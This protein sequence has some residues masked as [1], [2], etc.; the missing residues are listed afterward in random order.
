MVWDG[1]ISSELLTCDA[2]F[3][4]FH[5]GTIAILLQPNPREL[6]DKIFTIASEV[7]ETDDLEIQVLGG[8]RVVSGSAILVNSTNTLIG[9][10]I[11]DT[12][13]DDYYRG[14]YLGMT[15][16]GETKDIREIADY[17]KSGGTVEDQC[18]LVRALSG[19]PATAEQCSIY[20]MR[21]ISQFIIT[22]ETTL[23]EDLPQNSGLTVMGFPFIIVRARSTGATD[24]H[25]ALMTYDKDGV[26]A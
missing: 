23:T 12:E 14:M 8:N 9:L 21:P 7:G 16:G 26:S 6:L 13:A 22:A 5:D 4:A 24:A 20:H 1:F 17:D 11:G 18:T 19:T 2:N 10:A 25:I 3:E 15:Q